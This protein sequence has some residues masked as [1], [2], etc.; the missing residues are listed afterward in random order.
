MPGTPEPQRFVR[1][2]EPASMVDQ[3]AKEI[4]RSIL[5]GSLRPGQAFSLREIA[6]QLEISFIPVREALWQ[7]EAQGLVVT[8]PGRSAIV[9]PLSAEDLN[10][11][12]QLR[13]KLEPDIAARACRRLDESAYARLQCYVDTFGEEPRGIDDVYEAHRQ[14]HLELLRPAAT[15][16][17]LRVIDGLWH[18][19]ERYVRLA[20]A[21][22]DADP[23]EHLRRSHSHVVLLETFRRG[24]P[25]EVSR[26]VL[27]HLH[28]N[29]VLAQQALEPVVKP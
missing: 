10:G 29:E 8:R 9:T 17:D 25:H 2:V 22:R 15:T 24:D 19:A 18:A 11:I 27:H 7:L 16:W 13:R 20:F 26:E 4:R 6:A 28:E 23:N 1:A 12:Y 5:S 14:F 21:R 3:V